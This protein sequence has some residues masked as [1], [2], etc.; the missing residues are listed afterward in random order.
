[1]QYWHTTRVIVV[2]GKE[3]E[4]DASE[5]AAMI[6][7]VITFSDDGATPPTVLLA[8]NVNPQ[9]IADAA[10][11]AFDRAMETFEGVVRRADEAAA[12]AA[13]AAAAAQQSAEQAVVAA[14]AVVRAETTGIPAQP[15]PRESY[16]V[17]QE[18]SKVRI[19]NA[20]ATVASTA[21]AASDAAI[22]SEAASTLA[23]RLKRMTDAP[24]RLK[25]GLP[26]S[27]IILNQEE[28]LAQATAEFSARLCRPPE[29]SGPTASKYL[30]YHVGI[31][32]AS[33]AA[34][35]AT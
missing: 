1:M 29:D 23:G 6:E 18:A 3:S 8:L 30:D 20:R 2:D 25:R 22:A 10:D 7:R 32:P 27:V 11:A 33:F 24:G 19:A 34:L 17:A 16:D 28:D 35:G 15:M 21:V 26:D 31:A 4:A 5:I 12:A 9:V 14:V 13:T